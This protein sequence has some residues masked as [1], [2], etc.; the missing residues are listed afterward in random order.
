MELLLIA[1]GGHALVVDEAARAQGWRVAGFVDD[2][3]GAVLGGSLP[4]Q[5]SLRDARALV[6]R[7]GLAWVLSMGGIDTRAR[8]IEAMREVE[9]LAAVVV[10]PAAVVSASARVGRGTFIGVRAIVQAGARLGAHAIVNTGAIVEHECDVGE[11]VHLAPGSILGGRSV[12]GAGTLVG[13]GACVLP[14]VRIG[15]GCVVGAGATV[16]RDVDDGTTV[17]G[18]PARALASPRVPA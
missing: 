14:G 6:A 3:E 8:A 4:R 17:V 15:R 12:V 2:D 11:N 5:G 16:L 9:G 7:G 18:T 13:L 1:G 10:H